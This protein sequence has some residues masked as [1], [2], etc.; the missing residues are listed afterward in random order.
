MNRI[1]HKK[2]A[3]N[4]KKKTENQWQSG[5]AFSAP[6]TADTVS[7]SPPLPPPNCLH[8]QCPNHHSFAASKSVHSATRIR[9]CSLSITHRDRIPF[10]RISSKPKTNKR[11][12][13]TSPSE[14]TCKSTQNAP[15]SH[16][17]APKTICCRANVSS[18]WPTVKPHWHCDI[19]WQPITKFINSNHIAWYHPN[20]HGMRDIVPSSKLHHFHHHISP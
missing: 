2:N 3:S 18:P 17:N 12:Q 19:Q 13:T 5:C 15:S 8:S 4:H 14:T 9:I 6:T 16:P 7:I 20:G 10:P 1:G 11:A